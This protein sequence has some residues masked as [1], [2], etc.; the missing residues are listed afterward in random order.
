MVK[1][2]AFDKTE[3]I[4]GVDPIT[5]ANMTYKEALETK[6]EH[7][8]AKILLCSDKLKDFYKKH[9]P[10]EEISSLL[11]RLNKLNKAKELINLQLEE[12]KPK[13]KD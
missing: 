13:I 9:V 2:V 10:Y 7:V 5:L 8:E 11:Q 3:E 12:I 1:P 4:Y 6:K